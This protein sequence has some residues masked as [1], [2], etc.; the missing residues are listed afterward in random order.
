MPVMIGRKV[1]VQVIR[2]SA[3]EIFLSTGL[4]RRDTSATSSA[5]MVAPAARYI[6]M[7]GRAGHDRPVR[8]R[9]N[10]MCGA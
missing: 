2:S 4:V 6:T 1:R 8:R 10:A 5:M 9:M 3:I 7:S